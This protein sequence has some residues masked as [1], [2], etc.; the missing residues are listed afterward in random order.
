MLLI[1]AI[2]FLLKDHLTCLLEAQYAK[3]GGIIISGT[4]Q[5]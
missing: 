1:A 2:L 4:R 3:C 5:P